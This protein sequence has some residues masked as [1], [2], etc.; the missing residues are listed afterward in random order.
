MDGAVEAACCGRSFTPETAMARGAAAAPGCR[1]RTAEG[2][3]GTGRA[4]AMGAVMVAAAAMGAKAAA[5][6]AAA[7]AAHWTRLVA[8]AGCLTG[9]ECAGCWD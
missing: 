7:E 6:G 3:T 9:W 8:S 2:I 5:V 4:A 1:R